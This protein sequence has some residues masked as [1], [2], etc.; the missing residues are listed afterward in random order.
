MK[1]WDMLQ[2]DEPQK[3]AK[4]KK[5]DTMPYILWCHLYEISKR[6]NPQRQKANDV[7]QWGRGG[8]NYLKDTNF[9]WEWWNVLE[10]DKGGGCRTLWMY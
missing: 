6:V 9:L 8:G 3:Y 4:W 7:W 2:C 10:R 5:P 1:Y